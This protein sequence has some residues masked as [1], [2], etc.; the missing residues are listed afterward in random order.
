M[1]AGRTPARVC[2]ERSL[3][4]IEGY[5]ASPL[6][7]DPFARLKGPEDWPEEAPWRRALTQVVGD[8]VRPAYQ[9]LAGVLRQ[10]LLPVARDDEHCGLG[11]LSDGAQ[12]YAT[13]MRH[14]TSLDITAQEVHRYG[15][16]EVTA[17]LPG[18]YAAV[19][20]RLF[21][22]HDPAA[23][24]ERLR[25]DDSLRYATAEEIMASA[26][27]IV[28]TA[29]RAMPAWF[30]RLPKSPCVIEPVPDFLAADSPGAYY[31]PPAPDGSRTGT[32]FVNTHRPEDKARYEAA[33]VGFHEAIPGHHLQL[34]IASE[35]ND[36]P[37]FRRFSL[38]NAAY[39]EGWGLYSERLADEM[40]LYPGDL[41]RIGMLSADSLRSCRLVVDTGLHAMGWSRDRAITFM[42]E[43]TPM[44]RPEVEV[45]IDRYIAMPAQALAYKVGQREI[46][47]LRAAAQAAL[48]SSF[49][50]KGFHDTVLGSGS[51]GL[52]VLRD[53]VEDWIAARRSKFPQDSVPSFVTC[54][55]GPPHSLD[56]APRQCRQRQ[57]VPRLGRGLRVG[58]PIT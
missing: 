5:L 40:G 15:M 39:C 33:S 1:A 21:G 54:D 46:F 58:R 50:L 52:L 48:G 37:R 43:H 9:R 31:V 51:V 19:G 2:I 36:L 20:G 7:K 11:S 4:V 18:E 49:D 44:S 14:H 30:G 41:D 12:I 29:W 42:V 56:V 57:Q 53:V 8:E 22:L 55:R 47:R 32:Y 35:L 26:Q 28:E 27:A 10:Q 3:N 6:E 34:T 45:E 16:D 24:F 23:I 13:L 17:K 38:V 25:H